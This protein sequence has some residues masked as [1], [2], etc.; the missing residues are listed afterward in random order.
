[1]LAHKLLV[2]TMKGLPPDVLGPSIAPSLLPAQP[3][4]E[5]IPFPVLPT[6]IVTMRQAIVILAL[7][8]PELALFA[9]MPPPN[10]PKLTA[11][12]P[13]LEATLASAWVPPNSSAPS[14]TSMDNVLLASTVTR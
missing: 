7:E 11:D 12:A 10:A 5:P 13:P 4:A 1:V 2:P 8:L 14:P 6:L 3:H 9:Q